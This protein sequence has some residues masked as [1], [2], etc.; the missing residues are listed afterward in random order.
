MVLHFN[1]P[2]EIVV[3]KSLK[4]NTEETTKKRLALY[5]EKTAPIIE[6]YSDIVTTVSALYILFYILLFLV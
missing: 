3:A 6:Y 4:D 5:H 1:C 2:D